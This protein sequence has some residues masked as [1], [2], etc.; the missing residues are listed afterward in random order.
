MNG[1][2]DSANGSVPRDGRW[3]R[4]LE[5]SLGW[6]DSP[7]LCEES[8]QLDH[9]ELFE[10]ESFIGSVSSY[11]REFIIPDYWILEILKG[12]ISKIPWK[13]IF[14]PAYT[15]GTVFFRFGFMATFFVFEW[16]LSRFFV[17]PM[18]L[19]DVSHLIKL[20]FYVSY[21]YDPCTV[22]HLIKSFS[23]SKST[24]WSLYTLY[25]VISLQIDVWNKAG[26]H[27]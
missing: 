8:V 7:S 14:L 25:L 12:L 1:N 27:V 17:V 20:C 2:G 16:V 21:K 9:I 4:I 24:C 11:S 26:R 13:P 19:I 10:R 23:R 15:C 3:W 18:F 22:S 6:R 5:P